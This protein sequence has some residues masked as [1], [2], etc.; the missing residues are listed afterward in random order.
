[1]LPANRELSGATVELV[2]MDAREYVLK[3]A[4]SAARDAYDYIFI[5]CPPSLE[6]LTVNS[7]AAAD[8]LAL[9]HI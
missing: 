3:T 4:L 6:L 7:L 5:D 2:D 1:M 8:S 9:I